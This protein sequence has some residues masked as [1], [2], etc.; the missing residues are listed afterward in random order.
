MFQSFILSFSLLFYFWY[1][2]FSYTQPVP[3]PI[4]PQAP[5]PPEKFRL[6][7]VGKPDVLTY[8][9]NGGTRFTHAFTKNAYVVHDKTEKVFERNPCYQHVAETKVVAKEWQ[10]YKYLQTNPQF[11]FPVIQESEYS[12]LQSG[13]SFYFVCRDRD[14]VRLEACES[15]S[16]FQNE[17]CIEVSSCAG[18]PDGTRL[19]MHDTVLKFLECTNFRPFLKN[20]P[21]NTF[22]YNDRCIQEK[23]LSYY[24]QLNETLAPLKLNDTTLV[25]CRDRKPVFKTCDPGTQLFGSSHTCEPTDCVGRADGDRLPLPHLFRDPFYFA[26][27]YMEC[28]GEKVARTEDCPLEW[29]ASQTKGDNLTMLP[30]VFHGQ[31]CAIP[32]FCENVFAHDPNVIV[33]VHE[34]TKHVQNWSLSESYDR[35]AGYYCYG[36]A[37]GGRKRQSLDAGMRISKRFKIEPAC[38][39]QPGQVLSIDGK[40]HQYYDCDLQLIVPC[41]P[42]EFFDGQQ[43]RVTPEHAFQYRNVPL[44]NFDA[45]N[46]EAWIKPFDYGSSTIASTRCHSSDY[47]F[48]KL[49]DTCV[50]LECTTYPFLS[51]V[52]TLTLLLPRDQQS[53]CRYD[54]S[55]QHI[56]KE[57]V[58]F[59]YTFWDQQALVGTRPDT[60]V[61]GQKIQSGNFIWDSTVYA[62]CDPGQPFLFCPSPHTTQLIREKGTFACAP[63]PTNIVRHTHLDTEPNPWTDYVRYEVKRIRALDHPT[64]FYVDKSKGPFQLQPNETY[65]VPLNTSFT[66]KTSHPLDLELRSRVTFP[67]NAYF[68]Y[69]DTNELKMVVALPDRGYIMRK[70]GFTLFPIT[71]PTYTPQIHVASFLSHP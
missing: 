13:D 52:P 22:F 33:P 19:P 71:L 28:F 31:A 1:F 32:T 24:C 21:A 11:T 9:V 69:S 8:S 50:H 40:P 46:Y 23:D 61:V 35:S 58:S 6:S 54:A 5:D 26:P 66:L 27:G 51:M 41:D 38:D 39:H 68:E 63:P 36:A 48:L 59:D 53:L 67:P 10:L 43:C 20:C 55:D 30:M 12:A 70:D 64:A 56:K 3:K 37:G 7:F 47:K 44:F 34:F 65:D 42:G 49:Y 25:E 57:P 17:K 60:C 16:F 2:Y 29:D 15:G 4:L 45:L 62:T 14:I 18:Q